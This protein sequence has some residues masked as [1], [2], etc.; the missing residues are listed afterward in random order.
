ML[1]EFT[2]SVDMSTLGFCSTH[3]LTL[4]PGSQWT[5]SPQG[6][7]GPAASLCCGCWDHIEA[8]EC[9][10]TCPSSHDQYVVDVT[11]ILAVLF[12]VHTLT[13]SALALEGLAACAMVAPQVCD[14]LQKPYPTAFF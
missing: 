9:G 11:W 1:Y 2:P 12:G 14:K 8:H 7:V 13:W 5:W 4:T 3:T 6:D 10:G